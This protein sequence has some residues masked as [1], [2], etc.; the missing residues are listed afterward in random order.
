MPVSAAGG[1]A[2]RR[3]PRSCQHTARDMRLP[4][5][6][7][8]SPGGS[9]RDSTATRPERAGSE[10]HCSPV[11]EGRAPAG[12]PVSPTAGAAAR[13]K[14]LVEKTLVEQPCPPRPAAR[15]ARALQAV[16]PRPSLSRPHGS[17]KPRAPATL[18]EKREGHRGHGRQGGVG[19]GGWEP[20]EDTPGAPSS[21]DRLGDGHL[22]VCIVVTTRRR[23]GVSSICRGD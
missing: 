11:G 21:Y 16:R 20:S 9:Q 3:R 13:E 19:R 1:Q 17:F 7:A 2:R 23:P 10:V 15:T 5:A 22:A 14:R 12:E 8:G 18:P 4:R 6:D